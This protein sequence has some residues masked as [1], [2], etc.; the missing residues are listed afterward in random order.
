VRGKY[1]GKK[2]EEGHSKKKKEE[3]FTKKD[4]EA[5]LRVEAHGAH[6]ENGDLHQGIPIPSR[7]GLG[8]K[9]ECTSMLGKKKKKCKKK[10]QRT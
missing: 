3:G 4:K 1:V 6:R 10:G 7:E 9:T 5:H 2:K 8:A